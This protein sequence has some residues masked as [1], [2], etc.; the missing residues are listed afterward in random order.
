MK[1]KVSRI[2][3]HG[4]KETVK[5]PETWDKNS[6]IMKCRLNSDGSGSM[7]SP[8][9]RALTHGLTLRDPEM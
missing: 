8:Y 3:K 1:I 4:K 2:L 5:N 7:R 6:G 9:S